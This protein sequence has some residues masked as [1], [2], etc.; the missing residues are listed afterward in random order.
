LIV[1]LRFDIEFLSIFQKNCKFHSIGV[2]DQDP[3]P[4]KQFLL[5]HTCKSKNENWAMFDKLD[6]E[7]VPKNAKEMEWAFNFHGF[8]VKYFTMKKDPQKTFMFE[9]Y[10]LVDFIEWW[11][12]FFWAWCSRRSLQDPMF[13]FLNFEI[14]IFNKKIISLIS[15]KL[16]SFFLNARN[17][18]GYSIT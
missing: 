7:S 6:F 14:F 9:R 18:I 15:I 5:T 11:A 13:A 3:L 8:W 2:F 16:P 1:S 10:N 4:L 12:V 17:F